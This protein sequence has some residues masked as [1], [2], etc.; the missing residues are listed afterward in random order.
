LSYFILNK[1]SL[2]PLKAVISPLNYFIN[3]SVFLDT[4]SNNWGISFINFKFI[5]LLSLTLLGFYVFIK[6]SISGTDNNSSKF[7]KN[8][9]SNIYPDILSS[10]NKYNWSCLSNGA[11]RLMLLF[12]VTCT[13]IFLQ[14]KDEALFLVVLNSNSMLLGSYARRKSCLSSRVTQFL[15]FLVISL[16]LRMS[17]SIIFDI[18]NGF[19][20]YFNTWYLSLQSC[21]ICL[22][23]F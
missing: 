23:W 17:Y 7:V 1:E 21:V 5:I 15:S 16:S 8:I 2:S 13:M 6:L 14:S 9:P 20:S 12:L 3:I 4:K 10:I 18:W 22:V 19:S 11:Y